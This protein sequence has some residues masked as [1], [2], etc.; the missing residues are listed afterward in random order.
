M[1]MD[2]LH[3]IATPSDFSAGDLIGFTTGLLITVL[4]LVLTLRAA[5]LPGTPRANIVF[6]ACAFLWSAGG[7]ANAALLAAG[8]PAAA[9][10]VFVSRAVQLSGVAAFPI[11]VLAIWRAPR[12]LRIAACVSTGLIVVLLWS[13]AATH[14]TVMLATAYN[15]TLLL[16][17]GAVTSL[18]R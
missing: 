8:I 2:A 18:R 3:P 5:K 4:L 9:R 11:P 17:L 15:A 13:G 12:F 7:L 16:L 10:L 1:L 6:A 14:R